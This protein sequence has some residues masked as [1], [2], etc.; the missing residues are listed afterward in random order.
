M[1]FYLKKLLHLIMQ[2][3]IPFNIRKMSGVWNIGVGVKSTIEQLKVV[4][5][6]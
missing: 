5:F 2:H 3:N 6:S 1:T 4:S